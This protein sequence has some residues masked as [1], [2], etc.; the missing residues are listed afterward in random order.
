MKQSNALWRLLVS[1]HRS[2]LT[3]LIAAIV[4]LLR[5]TLVR[6]DYHAAIKIRHHQIRYQTFNYG[7]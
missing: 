2:L 5:R 6:L 1:M 4:L 7:R 3:K